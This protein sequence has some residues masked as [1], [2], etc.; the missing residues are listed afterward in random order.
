MSESFLHY[1]WKYQYF[2]KNNFV[3]THGDSV[4]IF[5]TGMYNTNSGPDFLNA[6]V[7]V[8]EM[9]WVGNIEIHVN[10]SGWVS[11]K[12]DYD[13]AY[14]NVVLHVV[15]KNDREVKRMDGSTIPTIELKDRVEERLIFE[16]KKLVNSISPVPCESN[17]GLVPPIVRIGALDSALTVRLQAKATE[18]LAV[19]DRNKN[20]WEETCYQ[21]L[22]RNFGFKVNA[23]PFFQLAQTLPYKILR[24][25]IDKPIQVEAL[26]FGC[27]GFLDDNRETDSYYGILQ[28]EFNLLRRKY[29]LLE[30]SLHKTQWKF[31]RLRPANFPTMRLAQLASL[32]THQQNIFSQ[33]LHHRNYVDLKSMFMNPPSAYW[34]THYNFEKLVPFVPGLGE[35][36]I[37]NLFINTVVPVFAAYALWKDDQS[38]MDQ[39]L[40]LLNHLPPESNLIIRQWESLGVKSNTA[41][42]SQALIELYNNFCSRRRCLDCNMG[43]YLLKPHS[44]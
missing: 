35:S 9:Q 25:H 20:D 40:E 32:L 23:A 44:Q 3:T 29:S 34:T 18:V 12:H 26:L 7:K 24:K 37:E 27:A 6:R 11:H 39:A 22:S 4:Q 2:R 21:L 28:R 16:Y 30:R 14:E 36:S 15:W 8:G 10:A 41:F 13:P 1:I 31:L 17:F 38:Y 19:L 43:T 33:L 42:D 5:S